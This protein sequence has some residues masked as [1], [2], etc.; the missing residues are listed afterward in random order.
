MV[1]VNRADD[2][3]AGGIRTIFDGAYT[4]KQNVSDFIDA[5]D[6]R[7]IPLLSMLGMGSEAGSAVAGADSLAFPC[8]N[9]THTWQSDELIPSKATLTG[10][11]TG[12]PFT[13]VTIGTTAVDYFNVGDLVELNGTYGEVD[14]IS[15]SGGTLTIV[16]ADGSAALAANAVGD[17]VYNLGSMRLDGSAFT[18]VYSSPDLGS[19]SNYTK[20]FHD[21][22]SFS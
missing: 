11:D 16:L 4:Q 13:T 15:S 5:I 17:I 19:S 22:V 6:P 2:G 21:A 20:I 18:T 10:A 12:A 7:D 1:A 9:P 14:S 8:I 3:G